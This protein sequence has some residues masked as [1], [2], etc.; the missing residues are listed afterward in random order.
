MESINITSHY[1]KK[2]HCFCNEDERTA[3]RKLF[4]VQSM[5]VYCRLWLAGPRKNVVLDTQEVG[6]EYSRLQHID[7]YINQ[8]AS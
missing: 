5:A 3:I 1:K 4:V 7:L 2:Q 6:I 8:P